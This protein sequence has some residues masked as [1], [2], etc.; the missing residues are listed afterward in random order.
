[1]AADVHHVHRKNVTFLSRRVTATVSAWWYS[2]SVITWLSLSG[3][4]SREL[5]ARSDR[6]IYPSLLLTRVPFPSSDVRG[7]LTCAS[8][9]FAVAGTCCHT[10]LAQVMHGSARG[11]RSRAG[12]VRESIEVGNCIGMGL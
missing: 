3:S 10:V 6:L 1:M 5:R 4:S 8:A 12:R 2:V 9:R 11:G 7:V